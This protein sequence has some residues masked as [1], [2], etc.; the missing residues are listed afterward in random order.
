MENSIQKIEN[1]KNLWDKVNNAD[2]NT[3]INQNF[4]IVEQ[5]G[6]F[7]SAGSYYYYI[8]NF[9]NLSMEFVS[10]D[11]ENILGISAEFFSLDA[12]LKTY[13]PEDLNAMHDKEQAAAHFLFNEIQ[14]K[15][16]IDYKVVY[17]NRIISNTGEEKTILHQAKAIKV[18]DK[19]K[20]HKVIGVHT[21]IS[22]LNVPMDHRISFISSKYPSHYSVSTKSKDKI[23]GT[24]DN[25]FS[26]REVEIIK[27]ISKG[28][29]IGEIGNALFISPLT[30]KTHKRNILKKAKVKN[31]VHLIT[32][33]IRDGVI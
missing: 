19:G 24:L 31:T 3:I 30:V 17:L 21:D 25:V 23:E 29:S 11:V 9:D 14:P 26:D 13:H 27:L 12:M 15:Q 10:K 33:C 16:I 22:Y 1:I 6:N 2:S 20:I 5:I 32:N 8:L 18:S 28:L 4:N 7:F